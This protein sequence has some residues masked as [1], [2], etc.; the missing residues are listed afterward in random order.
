TFNPDLRVSAVIFLIFFTN[1]SDSELCISLN[2]KTNTLIGRYPAGGARAGIITRR[3]SFNGNTTACAQA[4][5]EQIEVRQHYMNI[6]DTYSHCAMSLTFIRAS[7]V[8]HCH[9][10]MPNCVNQR[11]PHPMIL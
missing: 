2:D 7:I 11:K 5:C 10:L 3:D 4:C 1:I 8:P 9:A 6:Y